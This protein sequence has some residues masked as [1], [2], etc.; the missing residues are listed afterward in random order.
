MNGINQK[1]T[2]PQD[3]PVALKELTSEEQALILRH[4]PELFAADAD[5]K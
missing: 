1:G 4:Y 5:A 2:R 3:Q